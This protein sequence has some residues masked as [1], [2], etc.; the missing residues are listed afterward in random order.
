MVIGKETFLI[1]LLVIAIRDSDAALKLAIKSEGMTMSRS[2]LT[3]VWHDGHGPGAIV[4][5]GEVFKGR[6]WVS[7]KARRA[8]VTR[9]IQTVNFDT[10]SC[11]EMPL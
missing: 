9:V 5:L 8:G 1:E 7:S 11:F 10:S 6:F 4:M 3:H 2:N